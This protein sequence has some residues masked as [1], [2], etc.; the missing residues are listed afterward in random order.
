MNCLDCIN[1][2][3]KYVEWLNTQITPSTDDAAFLAL[4]TN[5]LDTT[6]NGYAINKRVYPNYC[7]ADCP[8]SDCYGGTYF[9]GNLSIATT[10]MTEYLAYE[11][12]APEPCCSN[13]YGMWAYNQSGPFSNAYKN[14]DLYPCCNSFNSSYLKN[15]L[16]TLETHYNEDP[17]GVH[18]TLFA[19]HPY[20]QTLDNGIMEYS[21]FNGDSAIG[22][23]L[24]ATATIVNPSFRFIFLAYILLNGLIITCSECAESTNSIQIMTVTNFLVNCIG[25]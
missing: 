24:T 22:D 3:Y 10:F 2:I 21:T 7:C 17:D 18:V 15:L 8:S 1:P 13:W 12:K 9:L 16:L 23:I 4:I 6:I 11:G 14:T 25:R 19:N 5:S 20:I